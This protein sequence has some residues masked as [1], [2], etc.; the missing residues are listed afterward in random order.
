MQ[1][2]LEQKRARRARLAALP[3]PEKVRIVE[4]MRDAALRIK[5][6]SAAAIEK[7]ANSR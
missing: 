3:Y 1:Q 4:R 6:A 2:I 7:S 5:A